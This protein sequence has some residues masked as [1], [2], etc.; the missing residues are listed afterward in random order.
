MAVTRPSPATD[1]ESLRSGKWW[2]AEDFRSIRAS[3]AQRRAAGDLA[4]LETV[5][6]AGL[7]LARS[8]GNRKAQI[9]YLTTIGNSRLQRFQYGDALNAYL[10]ASR[11]AE[12]ARDWEDFGAI[13][14]NLSAVYQQVGDFPS[15]LSAA[16]RGR[17]AIQ[18]LPRQPFYKAQ[19][20]LQLG[21]LHARLHDSEATRYFLEG[22]DAAREQDDQT[23]EKHP[24]DVVS[25]AQ[26]WDLLGSERLASG[27]LEE[28]ESAFSEAFRL[29][30]LFERKQL[31]FSYW[32]LGGLRLAQ[33]RLGEAERFTELA[34]Q[35][36][37]SMGYG[38][39]AYAL[40]HQRGRI[41]E[42]LGKPQA[43]LEDLGAA[44]ETAAL[45]RLEV[46]QAESSLTGA[47]VELDA[48]VFDSFVDASARQALR[49]GNQRL[50]EQGFLALEINRAASLRET[51]VLAEV[52]R[53]KLPPVFWETLGKVRAAQA[54]QIRMHGVGDG[55]I[56][57]LSLELTEMEA[58]AGLGYSHK[59]SESF[60]SR[61][62][63]IHFQKGLGDAELLLS[64][65]LGE[66]E[67]YLWAVTRDS[68]SL[69]RL[70]A[71]AQVRAEVRA[72]RDAVVGERP[73]G[74]LGEK[75]YRH[76]FGELTPR[77]TRKASWL[78]SLDGALFDL[79]FAALAMERPQGKVAYLIE[80]HSLQV[81]P[82]A[83][84]LS[85]G[86]A[87]PAGR[88]LAVADPIYN[89]ADPRSPAVIPRE[90]LG[91]LGQLN[92]LVASGDEVEDSGRRWAGGPV[93]VLAGTDA[94]KGAF[95]QALSPDPPAV[96][97]LATHVLAQPSQ[98]DQAF[99]AFSLGPD[100]RPD[101]IGTA[102]VAMLQVP[103]SVV[104]MTGCASATGEV[105]PGAGL[106]GLARAWLVAGASAVVATGWPVADS[107]GSLLPA[108]YSHL[109][110]SSTAEALRRSQVEMI[111]S[112]T[113]QAA[114]GYWAAFQVAGGSR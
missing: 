93:Q 44:V 45:W 90:P 112:G 100:G 109:R 47:N 41:R 80:R 75:L 22:I 62:S 39:A 113:W 46:P 35:A 24:W 49:S 54:R 60:R 59:I 81:I 92:R 6:Q 2:D 21:R 52:W 32:Q 69:Y 43:A 97:H 17:V 86:T 12:A 5:C 63:L 106:L 64:F 67:S 20:L 99:L 77:E 83:F 15:A 1:P 40:L 110:E 74:D 34:I 42:A 56:E 88:Y 57:R 30:T 9:G 28:A 101:L 38:P 66:L 89:F 105:V 3:A 102:D 72:F 108:F 71:Q 53:R 55:E 13:S 114:P 103:G 111:G 73:S 11:L 14:G 26:A 96:I 70:P 29:R 91:S 33:S 16:E 51:K 58:V 27:N 8:L 78:L 23:L 36:V 107:R 104:V 95:L 61:N 76:L 48:Q 94:R 37:E 98:R 68:L 50:A 84:F 18:N 10:E 19:L 25:E 7:E 31:A 4:G 87:P 82:G 85:R 65:H 79:P